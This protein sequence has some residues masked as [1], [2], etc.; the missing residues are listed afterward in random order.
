[1]TTTHPD[2]Q[3]VYDTITELRHELEE[4]VDRAAILRIDLKPVSTP[5]NTVSSAGGD[6]PTG[7]LPCEVISRLRECIETIQRLRY[8]I[9]A[10]IENLRVG[11]SSEEGPSEECEKRDMYT[12]KAAF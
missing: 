4:T 8:D 5:V 11:G 3:T 7:Q 9:S 10:M 12:T 6:P 2:S 1:M